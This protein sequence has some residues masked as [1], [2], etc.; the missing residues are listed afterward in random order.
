MKLPS[1]SSLV[2]VAS[3]TF[4]RFPLAI[5]SAILATFYCILLSHLP[6]TEEKSHFYYWNILKTCYIGLLIFIAAKVYIET[7]NIDGKSAILLQLVMLILLALYYYTLP[8][9]FMTVDFIR[10]ILFVMVLHLIIS[11]VPFIGKG[12]VDKFWEY[13][14]ALFLSIQAT[15]FYTVVL[16]A[17]LA[18]ALLA[19][20]KLF[21]V[22][23]QGKYYADLWWLLA[24]IFN[25]W[26]FLA[27]FPKFW[28][29]DEFQRPYPKGLKIFTQY[30]LLPLVTVYL[31][32]LYAYMFKIVITASWP[33]GWVSYLVI[34]FST[35]GVLSLLL[36]YPVRNDANNK[37]IHIFSRFFYMTLFPLIIL[38]FFAIKKRIND[39]GITE[40]RYFIL[41]LAL[42]LLFIAI[43]FL[44]SRS[45]N[46]KLIP[47]SLCILALA[48]AFGPW[49]AFSVS[50]RSQDNH[51]KSFLDK[52]ALLHNGKIS[53][54]KDSVSFKDNEQINSIILYLVRVHGYETLQHY[55]KANLDSMFKSK[56]LHD[57]DYSDNDYSRAE[58]IQDLINIKLIAGNNNNANNN[59]INLS[60]NDQ[61]D[62]MNI[63]G[64]DYLVPGFSISGYEKDDSICRDYGTDE[65]SL[66][67]CYY[68][69]KREIDFIRNNKRD[70]ILVCNLS[71]FLDSLQLENTSRTL[72]TGQMTYINAAGKWNVMILFDDINFWKQ[73]N[74]LQQFGF[75]AQIFIKEF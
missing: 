68:N 62:I 59:Y 34:G 46:I 45:K 37:W 18:L 26:F 60:R 61:S 47:V 6:Y 4:K 24:G 35:A 19:V 67:I 63:R 44:F 15:F 65:G 23:V 39:Y 25:T 14:K 73:R 10:F 16:Y 66:T 49:S 11:F 41:T 20:E 28:L 51:L 8:S 72:S 69:K 70:S 1:F 54:Q 7:K 53:P 21:N 56:K 36:V 57:N 50:L 32:I 71:S 33:S 64:Y 52:Y 30:V 38:L 12:Q 48:S 9:Q 29:A 42:W 55:F 27:A 17:G 31:L 13:N 22:N 40:N 75:N 74:N 58:K 43:Y 3:V 2:L 5:T